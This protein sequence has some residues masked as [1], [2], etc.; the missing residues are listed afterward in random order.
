MNNKLTLK[1]LHI[2]L[3]NINIK[4]I[5][6]LILSIIGEIDESYNTLYTEFAINGYPC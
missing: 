1:S 5:F 6:M 3:N 2:R 4:T